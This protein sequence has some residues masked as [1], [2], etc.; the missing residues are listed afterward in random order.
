MKK[1]TFPFLL[2]LVLSAFHVQAQQTEKFDPAKDKEEVRGYVIYL[3]PVPGNTFGFM[4]SKA[5]TTIWTQNNNPFLPDN[6]KGFIQK[7]DAYKLAK[8]VITEK[9][10]SNHTPI[11]FTPELAK[12]LNITVSLPKH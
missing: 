5:K 7:S 4:V 2:C 11:S 8:W 9:E 10:R 1:F 6:Q 3:L 12:Q